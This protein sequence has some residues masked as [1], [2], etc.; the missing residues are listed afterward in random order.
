MSFILSL[1]CHS[2]V[3]CTSCLVAFHCLTCF[4]SFFVTSS[5]LMLVSSSWM[6]PIV[7]W[8]G[9]SSPHLLAHLSR[10][11]KSNP[12]CE[13]TMGD[14]VFTSRTLNDTVN[15]KWNFNCQ[16]HIRDVYQDVLCITIYERDPFAPDGQSP[17]CVVCP[18]FVKN[19]QNFV[20]VKEYWL[21]DLPL[22]LLNC[23]STLTSCVFLWQFSFT[24]VEGA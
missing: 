23:T 13:V 19:V 18:D 16:F 11:G 10:S 4:S 24:P 3:S 5:Q 20:G 14:Q 15:P 17:R 12:Y 9:P 21:S 6:C 8:C 2:D 22:K 7:S 1:V